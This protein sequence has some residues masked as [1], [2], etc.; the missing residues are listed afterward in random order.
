MGFVSLT[1]FLP[2]FLFFSLH[3]CTTWK[4][5]VFW[6]FLVRIFPHSDW[7]QSECGKM[8]TRKLRARTLLTQ[9]CGWMYSHKWCHWHWPIWRII[10]DITMLVDF[11][12]T[13]ILHYLPR[14][15]SYFIY[16]SSIVQNVGFLISE[17]YWEHA[18]DI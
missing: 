11:E 6:V 4:V 13:L 15:L 5:S 18:S 2:M 14:T 17:V 7:I 9:C 12:K 16:L 10:I 3:S 1:H 8:G